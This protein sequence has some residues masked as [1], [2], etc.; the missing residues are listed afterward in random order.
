VK[1]ADPVLT[2]LVHRICELYIDDVLN[3]GKDPVTFLVFE[4]YSKGF[5]NSMSQ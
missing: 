2:G 1:G 3:H 5:A 4:R